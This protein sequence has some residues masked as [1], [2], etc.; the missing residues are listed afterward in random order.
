MRMKKRSRR[1]GQTA[2]SA[3]NREETKRTHTIR[4]CTVGMKRACFRN[5]RSLSSNRM[6]IVYGR[7]R[8]LHVVVV[9]VHLPQCRP[10]S[11]FGPSSLTLYLLAYIYGIRLFAAA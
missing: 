1:Q 6:Y 4:I 2:W 11:L 7:R 3:T 10:F 5:L 9:I 8:R